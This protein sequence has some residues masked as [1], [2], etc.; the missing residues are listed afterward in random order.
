MIIIMFY[1]FLNWL[2]FRGKARIGESVM[3]IFLR[4]VQAIQEIKGGGGED[5]ERF[6]LKNHFF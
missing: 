5:Q 1:F 6:I 2:I 4:E 3:E